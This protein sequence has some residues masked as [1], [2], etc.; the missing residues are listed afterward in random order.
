MR[1]SV[2]RA[3]RAYCRVSSAGQE[4]EGTSLEGQ[5]QAIVRWCL[6]QGLPAPTLYVEVES[7]SAEKIEARAEQ[8]R[9]LAEAEE[10][11]VV[12]VV[13]VDRWSRDIVHGV[14]SVRAVVA[15]GIRWHSIR[16]GIDAATQ[17]GDS[18]LGIMAWTAD[19][20]R[21][22]IRDRTV[23][24]RRELAD[25]GL[26]V[27]SKP[28]L[29]YARTKERR[30]VVVPEEAALV[31]EVFER[32]VAGESLADLALVLPPA[33]G[34][35]RW[36]VKAVHTVLR[37][38]YLLGESRR[39]DG[40]WQPDTHPAIVSRDL[41]DRA[42]AALRKRVAGGR[43][44]AQGD[45][46]RRLLRGIAACAACGRLVSVRFGSPRQGTDGDGVRVHYYVCRGVLTGDGCAEGW[47]RAHPIDA[48][49]SKLALA[50]LEEL[51]EELA[52]PATKAPVK[53]KPSAAGAHLPRIEERR[54]KV[55]D[56]HL[57]GG[58]DR[59][60]MDRRVA[61]LDEEAAKHRLVAA[62]EKAAAAAEASAADPERR[63][64]LL[65]N[66][67]AI[68][69]AWARLP[70]EKRQNALAA[71]AHRVEIGRSGVRFEWRSAV[72]L[73]GAWTERRGIT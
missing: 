62:R 25:A 4:R 36:T 37:C 22:R 61:L 73:D 57:D 55:V 2:P 11:D 72:E 10:G 42:H 33:R 27:G 30:L 19:Q 49:A 14:S 50:R 53:R 8:L 17:H 32:C 63:K 24:R 40:T 41:W 21:A 31:V 3:V 54:R 65:K 1:S 13:A 34:R 46:A 70:V 47:N 26:Y 39:G 51:R 59:A 29:G 60:E 23:G 66:V 6:A 44:Y 52:R 67:R 12:V 68:R 58:I 5:Q 64:A 71:L 48:E 20:E 38:R 69:A 7:G 16:E 28:S 56:L 15:R 35:T 45:S 9:L 18:T 43:K